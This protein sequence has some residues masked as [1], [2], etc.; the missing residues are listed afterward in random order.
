MLVAEIRIIIGHDLITDIHHLL[1][2]MNG[3]VSLAADIIFMCLYFWSSISQNSLLNSPYSP[4]LCF[5]SLL[6]SS[7][8]MLVV[9]CSLLCVLLSEISIY[10]LYFLFFFCF[11]FASVP[12]SLDWSERKISLLLLFFWFVCYTSTSMSSS[13][14]CFERKL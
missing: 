8:G 9:T 12:A 6:S 3:L 2:I 5:G 14:N 7:H 1:Y 11:G 10:E 4:P 13:L